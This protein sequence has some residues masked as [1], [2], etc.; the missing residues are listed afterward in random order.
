MNLKLAMNS[1]L[2]ETN[3]PYIESLA[4]KLDDFISSSCPVYCSLHFELMFSSYYGIVSRIY[5]RFVG[6]YLSL[7]L[8]YSF[9]L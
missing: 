3:E 9:T 6:F 7:F 2:L 1:V 5:L 4:L 8:L